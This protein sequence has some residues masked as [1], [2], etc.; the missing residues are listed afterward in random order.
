MRDFLCERERL[1]REQVEAANSR[2]AEVAAAIE[3]ESVVVL[4]SR[5]QTRPSGLLVAERALHQE[6]TKALNALEDCLRRL[7][8]EDQLVR[9][10]Q[11]G[12]WKHRAA[13]S[14]QPD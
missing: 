8:T 9:A 6:R 2:L 5:G 4:G 11:L 10:N 7:A 1:L 14:P 12:A 13:D 3:R